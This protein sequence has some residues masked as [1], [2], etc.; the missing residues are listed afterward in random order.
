MNGVLVVDKSK[1]KT[2]HDIVNY[3]RR[4]AQQRRVGHAGTLDPMATGVLVVLLGPTTRLSR[5]AMRGEKHYLGVVRLG[6]ITDTY[7]AA[8]EFLERR[9]VHVEIGDIQAALTQFRGEIQQI[10][11]M[12]AAIKV[13]GQK[14]YELARQGKDIEREPRTVTIHR[15]KIRDWSPPDLTL[16][17]ICSSGTYIRSLAHDLGQALGCGAHLQALRR[18][19][20]GSFSVTES[21]SLT[22][23][24]ALHS[25]GRLKEALLPARAALGSMPSVTLTASLEQAVRYGQT[26]SLTGPKQ[27]SL[28]QGLDQKGHLVAVLIRLDDGRYRP[29]VVLPPPAD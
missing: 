25:Q 18:T 14:L 3:V 12:F 20:S 21:Y 27:K 2:S 10:P 22:E 4:L 28:L 19:A 15:V 16:D 24:D 23:L 29:T 5:F 1:G 26:V 8:G 7:D 13:K 17:V 11:P 6:Q 9:P